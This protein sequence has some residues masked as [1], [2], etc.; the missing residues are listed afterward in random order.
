MQGRGKSTDQL[1]VGLVMEAG[2]P[3]R[4][5]QEAIS[6]ITISYNL[7]DKFYTNAFNSCHHSI[8][9]RGLKMV[10]ATTNFT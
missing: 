3:A 6:L 2:S 4:N 5:A 10:A 8:T 9:S 7:E 1:V